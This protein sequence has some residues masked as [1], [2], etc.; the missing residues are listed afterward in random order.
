MMRTVPLTADCRQ[1][2][3]ERSAAGRS[4]VETRRER[5]PGVEGQRPDA[6]VLK[7]EA[8][9]PLPPPARDGLCASL[10]SAWPWRVRGQFPAPRSGLGGR[11]RGGGV[12]SL[13]RGT[14]V[15]NHLYLKLY[16]KNS[17]ELS[18]VCTL[19]RAWVC[20]L[21]IPGYQPQN[22]SRSSSLSSR[23]LTWRNMISFSP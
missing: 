12:G 19:F 23:V 17:V 7:V 1:G 11:W 9:L 3:R 6:D 15:A 18:I 13:V 2:D 20:A 16:I 22:V 14:A 5:R 4:G 10:R 21:L 8:L